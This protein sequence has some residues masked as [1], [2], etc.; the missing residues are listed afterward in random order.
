MSAET[1]PPNE[2]PSF[3]QEVQHSQISAR[4]PEKVARGVFST[5]TLVLQG[6]HEFILDF[7]LRMNQPHQIVARVILPHALMPGLIAAL[8]ENLNNFQSKFGPCPAL[9]V[10]PP[11]PQPPSIEE[12]YSQLKLPDEVLSGD[13]A[14]HVM[15]VHSP[16]EFCFEFITNFYPRSAVAARVF[17]SVPQVPVLLNTLSR[18]FQQFQQRIAPQ[19]PPKPPPA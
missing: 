4:V 11:P 6:P 14:N 1:N 3:T 9:P 5:G 10:S 18:A 13:Y 12:I 2:P 15:I 16:S 17:M 7:V 19:Q 8:R